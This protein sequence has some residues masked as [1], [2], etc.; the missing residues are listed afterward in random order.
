[1]E[2]KA[3]LPSFNPVGVRPS[4]SPK[5]DE[6]K[7][8]KWDESSSLLSKDQKDGEIFLMHFCY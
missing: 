7:L 4:I 6:K 8:E 5:Y 1:M 3:S 2:H